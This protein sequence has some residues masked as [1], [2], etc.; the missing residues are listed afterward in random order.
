M[1]IPLDLGWHT[2]LG[3]ALLVMTVLCV[4]DVIIGA[5][6]MLFFPIGYFSGKSMVRIAS[7]LA[8]LEGAVIFFLGALMAFVRSIIS[9]KVKALV[10]V[11]AAMV[12]FSVIFGMLV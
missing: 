5:F 1:R 3:V 8:F 11:G 2:F 9:S 4:A 10:V 7:D 12:G 6:F